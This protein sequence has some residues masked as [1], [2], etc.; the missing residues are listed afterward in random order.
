MLQPCFSV[1][2]TAVVGARGDGSGPMAGGKVAR[3]KKGRTAGN[4]Q[5]GGSEINRI[6]HI[7]AKDKKGLAVTKGGTHRK[8]TQICPR[9]KYNII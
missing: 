4:K 2:K 9:D 5:G 6:Y 1:V 8:R 3:L 7:R